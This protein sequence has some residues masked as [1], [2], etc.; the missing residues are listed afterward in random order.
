VADLEERVK[1]LEEK[2]KDLE[3]NINKS[4]SEIKISLAEI[5]ASLKNSN[6]SGDLKNELIEKDVKANTEKIKVVSDRTSKLE[7]SNK[8]VIRLILGSIIG[9]VLEAVAFY[10]KTKP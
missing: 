5:S 1:N 4:L 3:I 2:I 7:D 8:W 9:L 10:I 6:N